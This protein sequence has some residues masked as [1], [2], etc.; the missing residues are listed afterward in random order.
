MASDQEEH[1]PGKA[2]KQ[3]GNSPGFIKGSCIIA[4]NVKEEERPGGLK[5]R[6][7]AATLDTRQADT[8]RKALLWLRQHPDRTRPGRPRPSR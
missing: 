2:E 1:E 5:V 4:Y 3:A 7:K 8:I 6:W